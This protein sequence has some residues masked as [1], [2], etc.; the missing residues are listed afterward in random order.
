MQWRCHHRAFS[1]CGIRRRRPTKTASWSA[2]KFSTESSVMTKVLLCVCVKYVPSSSI[3]RW[4]ASGALCRCLTCIAA[5][6]LEDVVV[7]FRTALS[8]SFRIRLTVSAAFG[9]ENHASDD[10]KSIKIL[11]ALIWFCNCKK[12][13]VE[14]RTEKSCRKP[15]L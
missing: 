9:A 5:G 13:S 4:V 10:T 14:L 7:T 2:T 8:D 11:T 6:T 1:C 15:P 12:F 3:H